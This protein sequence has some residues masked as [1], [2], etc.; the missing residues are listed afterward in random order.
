MNSLPQIYRRLIWASIILIVITLVGTFGY[1]LITDRQYSL[2]D[3]FYM[4]FITIATIGYG[5]I[6]D[7]SGNVGGRVFTVF[8]SIAGIGVLAY[9][10]TNV[11]AFLVEGE[12]KDSFRTGSVQL[13]LM[14]SMSFIPLADNT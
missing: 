6:I 5:E 9:V 1:W 14:S 10:A 3:A 4:T 8:I 12:L 2:F 11:T 13:A 7:L